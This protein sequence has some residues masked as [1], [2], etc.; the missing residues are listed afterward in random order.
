MNIETVHLDV[1]AAWR[2]RLLTLLLATS[3]A[4]SDVSVAGSAYTRASGSWITDGFAQGDEIMASGFGVSGNNGRAVI[5][6]LTALVMTVDRVLTTES[7]G[8]SV[9]IKAELPQGRKWEGVTYQPQVGVPYIDESVRPIADVT[10]SIGGQTVQHVISL[11][12]RLN[13]PAGYGTLA[14]ERM[15]G[16]ILGLFKPGTP[17]VYGQNKGVVERVERKALIESPEWVAC[18]VS[19]TATAYSTS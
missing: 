3:G 19:L 15:A 4:I 1:R 16:K 8:A 10:R 14:V 7:A 9:T 17:L 6:T 13:Y 12:A 5:V 11:D 18:P 2:Q